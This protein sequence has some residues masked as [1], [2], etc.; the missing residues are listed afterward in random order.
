MSVASFDAL[1]TDHVLGPA[2]Y[3]DEDF[4]GRESFHLPASEVDHYD[5]RL[6]FWDGDTE[7]GTPRRP[8]RSASRP[9]SSTKDHPGGWYGWPNGSRR[10]A[11]RASHASARR[12]W[13]AGT[14]RV[15]STG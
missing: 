1:G 10:C 3:R 11:A 15:A 4:P 9:P 7:T 13:C 8:G 5:G 12:I 14:R 2:A 6:E